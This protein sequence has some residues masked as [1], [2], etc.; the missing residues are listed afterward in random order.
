MADI[1]EIRRIA[2]EV[3]TAM[4]TLIIENKI[5]QWC[6]PFKYFPNICCGDMSIIL[7]THFINLGFDHPD[8][9]CGKHYDDDNINSHA[10]IRLNGICIDITADQFSAEQYDRVIKKKKKDYP[11]LNKFHPDREETSKY[12]IDTDILR[13]TYSLIQ[14]QLER[15]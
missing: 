13:K 5:P 11:L 12:T 14:E 9:I 3:R 2:T 6:T 4:D 7:S 10:W 15:T 8:Y 1:E